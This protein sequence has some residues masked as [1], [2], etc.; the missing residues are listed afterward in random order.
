MRWQNLIARGL[1]ITMATGC[2]LGMFGC[3]TSRDSMT[4]SDRFDPSPRAQAARDLIGTWSIDLRPDRGAEPYLKE[5]VIATS[6]GPMF[7]GVVYDGSPF[8]S[9]VIT[10]DFWGASLSFVSDLAGEKGGPYFWLARFDDGELVG[11][12]RSQNRGFVMPWAGRKASA[13]V[14]DDVR[15]YFA[16]PKGSG[17]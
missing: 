3:K 6:D 15:A 14:P 7:S 17:R 5:L 11:M 4:A 9:G 12:V 1:F 16:S 8:D 2:A 10:T 13:S